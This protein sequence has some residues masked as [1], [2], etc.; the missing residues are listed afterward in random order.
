MVAGIEVVTL[1]EPY[2][3]TFR[4]TG[5]VT[6]EMH[7]TF[8]EVDGSVKA[9]INATF[10]ASGFIGAITAP[11]IKSRTENQMEADLTNFKAYIEG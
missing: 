3:F 1:D 11:M 9:T 6:G 8:E 7:H 5:P 2:L 10:D 4:A